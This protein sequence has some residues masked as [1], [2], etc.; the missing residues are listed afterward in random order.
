LTPA[1][2]AAAA[3]IADV[4]CA[5]IRRLLEGWE[6]EEHP[7]GLALIQRFGRVFSHAPPAPAPARCLGGVGEVVAGGG[8]HILEVPGEL[9]EGPPL[10][11]ADARAPPGPRP[12]RSP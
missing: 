12:P 3:R 10:Q 8:D 5:E 1:G 4:R 2:R 6:P 11:L 9:R 7:G